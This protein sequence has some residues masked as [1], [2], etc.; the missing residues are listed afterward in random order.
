MI[1]RA[2]ITH[3]IYPENI[4]T[5]KMVKSSDSKIQYEF[6]FVIVL[7]VSVPQEHFQISYCKSHIS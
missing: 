1:Y 6:L 2:C 5:F 3:I 7:Y 4:D